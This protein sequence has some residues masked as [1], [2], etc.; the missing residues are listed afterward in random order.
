V[1]F[2]WL[3][4]FGHLAADDFIPVDEAGVQVQARTAGRR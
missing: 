2:H 1:A 3:E 4:G